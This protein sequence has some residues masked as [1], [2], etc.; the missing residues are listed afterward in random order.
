[1]FALHTPTHTINNPGPSNCFSPLSCWV[2]RHLWCLFQG[3]CG[4]M[5][6][7]EAAWEKRLC[8]SSPRSLYMLHYWYFWTCLLCSPL[9]QLP[10]CYMFLCPLPAPSLVVGASPPSACACAVER[11]W[12][13]NGWGQLGSS[14]SLTFQSCSPPN[15]CFLRKVLRQ[16]LTRQ[17]HGFS[18]EHICFQEPWGVKQK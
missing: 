4:G 1:M 15:S 16:N 9:V 13:L 6:C 17:Q 11:D 12:T 5:S 7:A 2:F 14:P 8:W 3:D 18:A 10:L